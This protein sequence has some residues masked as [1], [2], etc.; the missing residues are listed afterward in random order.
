MYPVEPLE[1]LMNRYNSAH[2]PGSVV[3]LAAATEAI[4]LR[5]WSDRRHALIIN[6]GGNAAS[7]SLGGIAVAGRGIVLPPT[8]W[9]E[10]MPGNLFTGDIHAI[11]TLGTV[12][13]IVEE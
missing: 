5:Q 2:T 8:A 6:T 13:S 10:I 3:A 4:V 1:S 9:Y 11:S 7:L 12:L